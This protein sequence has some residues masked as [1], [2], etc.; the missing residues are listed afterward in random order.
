MATG[1]LVGH[2]NSGIDPKSFKT[3][4]KGGRLNDLAENASLDALDKTTWQSAIYG[5]PSQKPDMDSVKDHQSLK[6]HFIKEFRSICQA[7]RKYCGK[8]KLSLHHIIPR[9]ESGGNDYDNLILLC[10]SCH[11]QIELRAWEFKSYDSIVYCF[12]KRKPRP[13]KEKECGTNW[14]SWVYGGKKNPAID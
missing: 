6:V 5:K 8:D 7:C 2:M 14:Q 12:T 9:D 13:I 10:H 4:V 11:N 1:S 3:D